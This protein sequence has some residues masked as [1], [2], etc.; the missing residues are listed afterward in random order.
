M[1]ATALVHAVVASGIAIMGM[2]LELAKNPAPATNGA[3]FVRL[4]GTTASQDTAEPAT[5]QPVVLTKG[6]HVI[7]DS[8]TRAEIIGKLWNV[9]PA[10]IDSYTKWGFK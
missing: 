9:T 7:Y 4:H 10:N 3:A 5:A 6:R 8:H 2:N 1:T